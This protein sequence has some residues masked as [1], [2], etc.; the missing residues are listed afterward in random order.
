VGAT[1]GDERCEAA[2]R[3]RGA[4]CRHLSPE[5]VQGR[6]ERHAEGD[7]GRGDAWEHRGD[8]IP[9]RDDDGDGRGELRD[10]DEPDERPRNLRR[11]REDLRELRQE[12]PWGRRSAD[13][14]F[15]QTLTSRSATSTSPSVELRAAAP[16]A[17][18]CGA[19]RRSSSRRADRGTR[20]EPTA[21]ALQEE[22]ATVRRTIPSLRAGTGEHRTRRSPLRIVA[23]VAAVVALGAAPAGRPLADE[24]E[25]GDAGD[26]GW[27]ITSMAVGVS[28]DFFAPP[29]SS[30]RDDDGFTAGLRL[31][32]ELSD[33]RRDE[34]RLDVSEQMITERSRSSAR[35]ARHVR[36]VRLGG[37]PR[38][39]ASAGGRDR[40]GLA[41]L[42]SAGLTRGIVG[43]QPS[44]HGGFVVQVGRA[45]PPLQVPL[46]PRNDDP[47]DE[48]HRRD[49]RR[50]Q[51]QAVG[52]DRDA[53][54]QQRERQVDAC[55]AWGSSCRDGE[56]R[57]WA[58]GSRRDG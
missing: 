38:R 28:D 36:L 51:P 37:Q 34:L 17:C 8:A 55:S 44:A 35:A 53:E 50:D 13:G 41:V 23:A 43:L 3:E 25:Q 33:G 49:E 11:P 7:G 9:G 22:H 27:R 16:V 29:S 4:Q 30:L 18:W 1:P 14:R 32:A 20:L 6:R 2:E 58:C 42:S 26:R 40:G 21:K 48:A 15:A 39:F 45:E 19:C 24:P 57:L 31:G 46:F 10:G 54:L 5:E 56:R 12:A 52:P 47:V